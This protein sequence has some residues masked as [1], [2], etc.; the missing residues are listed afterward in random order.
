[1]N[2]CSNC[3]SGELSFIVPEGDNRP[4]Y[5]CPN[6]DAIHYSNPKIVAGCLPIW[7]GQVLL[8]KRAIEPRLGFWN[9][10]SGYLENGETVEEGALREV[11]EEAMAR[12]VITQLHAI[13]SI[14][15]INQVYIHFLAQLEEPVFGVGS[16]SLEVRLFKEEDIPWEDIAFTSSRFTLT[17]YFDDLKKGNHQIH[18][19]KME[20]W[21]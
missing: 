19:G 20:R 5:V 14:P 2:F 11:W 10:P 17:N 3:G 8:A 1:M 7:Q 18:L 21:A 16:E 9:V 13:F 4:R 12:P 6:C 15:H